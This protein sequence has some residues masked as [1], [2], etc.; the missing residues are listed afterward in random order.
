[1]KNLLICSISLCFLISC[2]ADSDVNTF[3][4]NDNVSSQSKILLFS[5]ANKANPFDSKGKE[6]YDALIV[7]Q[8]QNQFPNS[9]TEITDQIR[10]V[11]SQFEKGRI[12][13][14]SVISFNETIVASI[15]SD[16]DNSMIQIVQSSLLVSAAKASLINFLQDLIAQRQLEFSIAYGYIVAYEDTVLESNTMSEDDKETILTVTSIS[17]YSLYSES[18]RK[19]RDWEKSAGNR[20]AK[21]F[22]SNNETSIISVIALLD[23]LI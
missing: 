20:I 1:M 18:E 8:K 16:P 10:F 13:S 7:Y 11:S 3:E 5:P 15:M 22:F 19:D 9:I 21:P 23:K 12:T 6:Y 2:S 14:R 17:R 4:I